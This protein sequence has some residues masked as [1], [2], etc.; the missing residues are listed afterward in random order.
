MQVPGTAKIYN[1]LSIS[2]IQSKS[3]SQRSS[4]S[5]MLR[6][7]VL[8]ISKIQSKSNSQLNNGGAPNTTECA[9]YFKDTI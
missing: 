7:N 9:Q 2:K 4:P 5:S 6:W 8:S 1:V 3:N